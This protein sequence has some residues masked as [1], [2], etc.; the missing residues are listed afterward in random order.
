MEVNGVYMRKELIYATWR[1]WQGKNSLAL[2]IK[3]WSVRRYKQ[4]PVSRIFFLLVLSLRCFILL[5]QF[6]ESS[7]GFA[8][9]FPVVFTGKKSQTKCR[10]SAASQ[11][12]EYTGQTKAPEANPARLFIFIYISQWFC[13]WR[14]R[15]ADPRA[16]ILTSNMDKDRWERPYYLLLAAN[17]MW[18]KSHAGCINNVTILHAVH[19]K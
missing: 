9:P 1:N 15:L 8:F 18:V 7:E 4:T 10:Y 13:A 19:D 5:C 17:F 6:L 12:V 3:G 2:K 16:Y 11:G 14:P